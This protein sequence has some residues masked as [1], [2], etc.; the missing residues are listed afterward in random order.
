MNNKQEPIKLEIPKD[1]CMVDIIS[2]ITDEGKCMYIKYI[3]A[4]KVR[5]NN[6]IEKYLMFIERPKS[7]TIVMKSSKKL[8]TNIERTNNIVQKVLDIIGK[9]PIIIMN[10]E[11]ELEFTKIACEELNLNIDNNIIY[12]RTIINN[13]ELHTR[14]FIHNAFELLT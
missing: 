14:E 7:P 12:G 6:T 13:I 3:A 8:L 11:R 1:Y 10:T 2:E 5:E 4:I 9:D